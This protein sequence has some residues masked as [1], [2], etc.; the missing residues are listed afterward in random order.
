MTTTER[1]QKVP[2]FYPS[3][4][5]CLDANK[6]EEQ[7]NPR[8]SYFT[9]THFT[10]GDEEQFEQYRDAKNYNICTKDVSLESNIFKDKEFKEWSKYK[11]I[12]ATAVINTFRYIFHKFKKGIFVKI[13]N[14]KLD[15]FLPFSKSCY[16]NEWSKQINVDPKFKDLFSFLKYVSELGGYNFNGKSILTDTERWYGNNCIIRYDMN[17]VGKGYYLSEGDS[18][19]GNMK[20]MLEVLC[21]KRQIPDIEFFINRRD[22]PLL[23]RDGTEPYNNLWDT[24]DKPL[25]SHSYSQYVPILSMC[26]SDRYAD[27]T[28]PTYEDWA[29]VQ[30]PYNV[31]FPK[32][33]IEYNLEFNKNWSSKKPT[34]VFRGGSTGCGVTIDTNSRLKLAYLSSITPNDKDGVPYLDAGITKWN[35]RPRKI[36]GEKYLQ[37]IDIK[38]L[39]FG[40][41]SFLTPLEQS[42]YK[43]IVNVDGH[44]SAFRLSLELNMGCV[45][46]MVDSNWKM[47]YKDMLVP[48]IHYVPVKKDLSD[49][50]EQIKWCRENDDKCQEI[51]SNAQSFF[52]TYLQRD[53]ILDYM[54]KLLVYLK[55]EMGIY[56]Y[57]E[58]NPLHVQ[59][60]EELGSFSYDFPKTNKTIV[61]INQVPSIGR[62]YG[63]L[64]GVHWIVNMVISSSNF[65]KVAVRD[66]KYS[67]NNKLSSVT[68]WK[69]AGFDFIVKSTTDSNKKLEH[70][71]DT[72]V[73]I[74]AIN[75]IAKT[76]P[77]FAYT[78][79]YY[80]NEKNVNV[81]VEYIQ[82]KTLFEYINS[83]EFRF[84]EYLM[85]VIQVCLAIEIAQQKCCLVHYDLTPWNIVLQRIPGNPI[86]IDYVLSHDKVLRIKTNIIPV[87]IDYGKSHAVINQEHHGFIN[88]FD[89]STVQDILTLLIKSIDQIVTT[90]QLDKKDFH[91]L[92]YLANFVSNTEY[93]REPFKNAVS[94]REFMKKAGKYACMISDE[95]YDLKSRTPMDL[96]DY[97]VKIQSEYQ[98]IKNSL[99]KASGKII[100]IMDKNNGRQVFD[101]ILSSSK[102]DRINS[103]INVFVRVKSCT[104]PLFDNLFLNYYAAQS[105]EN[106]LVSVRE[107]MIQFLKRENILDKKYEVICLNTLKFIKKLYEERI[108]E[109][110]IKKVEYEIKPIFDS[111]IVSPYTKETFLLPNVMFEYVKTH[112]DIEINDMSEY[113]EIVQ[114]VLLNDGIYK[115]NYEDK[116]YYL[117]MFSKILNTS[118]INMINNNA[119]IK[120]SRNV[121][122]KLYSK[123]SEKLLS[124][125]G[126]N[127]SCSSE[128]SEYLKSYERFKN[129]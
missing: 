44:V 74:N 97:I 33:C 49:L 109:I 27:I 70:I 16:T 31:W 67:E 50:I 108:N 13:A 22:F 4:Q 116:L 48:Y 54:Q 61:D 1:F 66:E 39:P 118:S 98:L 19:I 41:A 8:Y 21:S 35:L 81:I 36:Q 37:T 124:V 122:K 65:E 72:Y 7:T 47:W 12:D 112:L 32:S 63:K 52:D 78:F 71:H 57:N 101:Y 75:D 113:K 94:V 38:K 14:N 115:L 126:D 120:T 53:G 114:K 88:M 123:D 42:N 87:I 121:C 102:D 30:S 82:G 55:E 68:K 46:L 43:Y 125:L 93:R 60:E 77:N 119:N 69:M 91:N 76:I 15:V 80:E 92:I 90:K 127:E 99:D 129:I 9:Q 45:I 64:Q 83:N 23:T 107:N 58:D 3:R 106:N 6:N 26:T 56:L 96:V 111:L 85:I 103:Y 25:I 11:N 79:G 117:D 20:N 95:K 2:D 105:I 28:M 10:A 84:D 100:E 89:F 73:G 59:I 86:S 18:N 34:A 29:R 24:Y 104:L 40:K 62:C 110:K 51:V 5:E 17:R 128:V